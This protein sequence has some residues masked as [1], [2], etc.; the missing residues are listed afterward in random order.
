LPQT[1]VLGLQAFLRENFK[2][3]AGNGSCVEDIW[4]SYKDIIFEG[5]KRYGPQRIASKNPDLEYY[6]KEVKRLK[7][8]FRKM[9]N[10]R[11][12][13]QP[14]QLELKRLS[15]EILVAKKKAQEPFYVRSYRTKAVAGQSLYSG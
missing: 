8:K 4:K 5:I 9:Y 6:N 15:M 2:L 12:F 10:K 11:K 1:Y 14:Y 3:W 13:G 7:V